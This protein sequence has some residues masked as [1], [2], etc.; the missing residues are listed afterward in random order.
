MPKK[1]IFSLVLISSLSF[2]A[3]NSHAAAWVKL[4]ENKTSKLSIDKQSILEKDKLKRAWVKIEYKTPQKNLEF[5]DKEY[6]QAKLL[7][8]F[9]CD[10]QKSAA[11]QVFQYLDTTLVHSAAIDIKNAEFIE[12]VPET[13]FDRAMRYTCARKNRAQTSAPKANPPATQA[14]AKTDTSPKPS[15][16]SGSVTAPPAPPPVVEKSADAPAPEPENEAAHSAHWSYEGK[17]GPKEW[18]KLKPEFATCDTG[19]NQSPIDIDSAIDADLRPLKTLQKFP[20]KD[21]VNN[22]HT[23][24]A[25]FKDGNNLI[26]D[27]IVFKLKQVHFHTPSENTIKGKA[28]AMEA[29]FVHADSKGNLAVIGVMFNEGKANTGV[30]K[31]WKQMPKAID[32]PVNII[33]RILPSEMMPKNLDYYRFNGSLTT[34]PCSEG[35]R[36]IVIKT[37]LTASKAQIEAFRNIMKHHNNRPVQDINGRIIVE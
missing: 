13:E 33:S 11:A 6:N 7:W 12:P 2:I 15:S 32:K 17:A 5:P 18:G 37:P 16:E 8:Y 10:S 25:N 26:L 35:V 4:S 19:K 9:D 23:I 22:G 20:V 3:L 31:L 27:N 21:I 28:F 29:H 14:P 30:E 34:P 36:W 1:F 24:Q